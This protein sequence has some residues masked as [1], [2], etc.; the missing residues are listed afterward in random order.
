MRIVEVL[1]MKSSKY[2]G[3]ERFIESLIRKDSESQYWIWYNA[4]VGSKEYELKLK[5]MGAEIVVQPVSGSNIFVFA[6]RFFICLVKVKP[7][8]VHVHF[9]PAGYVALL[10]SYLLG[11][12]KRVKTVHSSIVNSKNIIVT[13]KKQ[14]GLKTYFLF[15]LMYAL[16]TDIL[17]V[18][19]AIKKQLSTVWKFRKKVSVLYLGVEVKKSD[20][21]INEIKR[22][23]NLPCNKLLIGNVAFHDD[24]KGIDLLLKSFALIKRS[25]NKKDVCLVQI[26]QFNK[27]TSD[28]K[29][30]ASEL[31][32]DSDVIWLGLQNN[33]QEIL[34]AC[35]IYTQPSR[36][37]GILLAIMEASSVAI[38]TVAYRVGGISESCVDNLIGKLVTPLDY[39]AFAKELLV[40]LNNNELR[41]CLGDNALSYM[42]KNFNKT[43]SI[44]KLIDI[45]RK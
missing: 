2:G 43:N 21:S 29:K 14:L 28:Y 9:D 1:G 5:N 40:L 36:S 17:C 19:N 15:R 22:K 38:P 4:P 11:V 6:W 27:K 41:R 12:K 31:G 10:L 37:E 25:K 20:L 23:Y 18:S 45:Y 13:N 33:V 24:V 3:L 7:D 30:L 44:K 34:S 26:G 32:I 35:D 8:V 39:E 42:M 16:S